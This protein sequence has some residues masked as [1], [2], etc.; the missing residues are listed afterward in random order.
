MFFTRSP[1][2]ISVA[3]SLESFGRSISDGLEGVDGFVERV[4]RIAIW[5]WDSD[6]VLDAEDIVKNGVSWWCGVEASEM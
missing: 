3:D 2:R 5:L 6:V 1:E 4:C